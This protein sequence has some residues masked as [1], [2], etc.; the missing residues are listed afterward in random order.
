M[1]AAPGPAAT[2][3]NQVSPASGVATTQ[4][5]RSPKG[6]KAQL[7]EP[8]LDINKPPQPKPPT[9]SGGGAVGPAS[10][11]HVS[12]GLM[13]PTSAVGLV[14]SWYEIVDVTSTHQCNFRLCTSWDSCFVKSINSILSQR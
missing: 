8:F 5:S 14:A 6:G 13:S 3:L 9:A 10:R 1:I 12:A 2:S 4:P 7:T 11:Y